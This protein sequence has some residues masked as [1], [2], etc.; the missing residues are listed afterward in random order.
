MFEKP[1]VLPSSNIL[2]AY[3]GANVNFFQFYKVGHI[4]S[5]L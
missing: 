2:G 3:L 5:L 4:F 1:P